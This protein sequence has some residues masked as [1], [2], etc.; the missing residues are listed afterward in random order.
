MARDRAAKDRGVAAPVIDE[1][2]L[3]DLTDHDGSPLEAHGFHEALRFRDLDSTGADLAGLVL[4]ECEVRG[5]RAHE[6]V[7]RGARLQETILE[8]VDAPALSAPRSTWRDVRVTGSRF[9][10]AE[11]YD[12][13]LAEVVVADSRLGWVNLRAARLG[14][15][16]VR[17]CTIEELDLTGAA[18]ERV[19]FEG[20]TVETLTVTDARLQDVD[21]RGLEVRRIDGLDGL[22]GATVDD[23]QVT[24]LAPLLA[25]HLGLRIEQ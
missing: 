2:R 15:V 12:A 23:H 5:W 8:R 18:L 20:T 17:D 1:L 6:A 24:L 21:L 11:L 22:R 7:L 13:D 19:R 10:S 3:V 16:L 4:S 14:D 9:G 25:A